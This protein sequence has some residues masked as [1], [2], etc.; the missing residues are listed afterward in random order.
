[1]SIDS[2]YYPVIDLA[3]K[4]GLFQ[5]SYFRN[6]EIKIETKSTSVDIL[7][8]VDLKSDAMI[9][10]AVRSLF[11]EDAIVSEEGGVCAGTSGYM[12][13]IDPLD[14][15]TN[16]SIGHPI[17]AVSIA[18]WY[19]EEPEFGVVYLPMLDE[20][21]YAQKGKGAYRDGDPIRVS[22]AQH[23]GESVI[24]TGFPYDR[25]TARNVNTEN[26]KRMV[27]LVKGIRRLGAAAYDLCLVASGVY[28]GYWEMRIAKWD[29][30]AGAL[31][32]QEAGGLISY[33]KVPK[34]YDV[35]CGN[36]SVF[37]AL[38]EVIDFEQLDNSNG[39]SQG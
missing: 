10:E 28:D 14:G 3:K 25:A 32:I 8:E 35:I 11:P 26:V 24:A 6:K 19:G 31:M 2:Q 7:T 27:P 5:K 36:P 13:I 21:Y 22:K 23:L 18:R 30:A 17:Y 1:M 34:G 16:Y 39:E 12:W 9:V 33:Q 4:V 38:N 37:R 15:T 20:V 29:L